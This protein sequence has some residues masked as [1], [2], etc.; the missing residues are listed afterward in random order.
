MGQPMLA[1]G[2]AGTDKVSSLPYTVTGSVHLLPLNAAGRLSASDVL[3]PPSQFTTASNKGVA[4]EVSGY[5]QYVATGERL[6]GSITAAGDHLYF[7][8]TSGTVTNI[9]SRGALGGSTYSVDLSA[10][11]ASGRSSLTTTAGGAG[12]TV[13][14]ATDSSGTT[15]VITVTD[16]TINVSAPQTGNLKAAQINGVGQT[17]TGFVGWFLKSTGH[18]Y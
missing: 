2:T 14:V 8:T 13:L 15:R 11:L 10:T 9:D 6:Y 17:P 12:G 16:Q 5:P 18:E 7:A 4:K 1:Y 3:G